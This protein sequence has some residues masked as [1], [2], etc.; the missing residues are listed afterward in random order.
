MK[1]TL[2]EEAVAF[3]KEEMGLGE[4]KGVRFFG[5][6]YGSSPVHEGF[7][8]A[9]SVDEPKAPLVLVEHEGVPFF[10]EDDDAWFF[11]DYDLAVDF[12]PK[13]EE[14]IYHFLKDG[15]VQGK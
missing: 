1:L 2:T 7:S 6:A 13:R 15:Q 4:G 12:D 5:K 9:L 8:L 3:Y 10:V 14:P 11:E